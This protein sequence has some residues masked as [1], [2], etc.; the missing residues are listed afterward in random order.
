M[1]EPKLNTVNVGGHEV[2]PAGDQWIVYSIS[3][4]IWRVVE[5]RCDTRELAQLQAD[6]WNEEARRKP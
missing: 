2:G 4:G 6:K 5:A 1:N 3:S